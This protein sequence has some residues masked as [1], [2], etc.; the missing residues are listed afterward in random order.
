MGI[1][2]NGAGDI[3]RRVANVPNGKPGDGEI[4]GWIVEEVQAQLRPFIAELSGV[5]S[6]LRSLYSNGSGGPP[7]YLETARAEDKARFDQLFRMREAELDQMRA[8]EDALLV[9]K[10]KKEQEDLDSAKDAKAL[11][12]KVDSSEKRFN[13][14]ITI[15]G[16]ILTVLTILLGLWNHRGEVSKSLSSQPQKPGVTSIQPQETMNPPY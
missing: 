11:A 14:R 10:T 12:D 2:G 15:L 7:G 8:I 5:K 9:Q 6:T 3:K 13:R 4:K 16:I 1:A